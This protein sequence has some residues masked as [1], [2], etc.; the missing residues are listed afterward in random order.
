LCSLDLQ[1]RRR[2]VEYLRTRVAGGQDPR[3][4]G[5]ALRGERAG[6]WRYRVGDYRLICHIQDARAE[7][8]VLAIGHRREIYR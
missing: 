5:K 3:R 4:F 2:I 7:V 8:L 1:V 6:L